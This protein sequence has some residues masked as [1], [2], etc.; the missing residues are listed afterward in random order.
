MSMFATIMQTI[1][2]S[3]PLVL[4][5]L[6]LTTLLIHTYKLMAMILHACTCDK[7]LMLLWQI[8]NSYKNK[9]IV[10]GW[11]GMYRYKI[12]WN[13]LFLMNGSVWD[14]ALILFFD[15][16]F[17]SLNT[18]LM[19]NFC[20]FF[21][22]IH[23]WCEN[24]C[25]FFH[26][27][28]FWCRISVFFSLNTL[29]KQKLSNK[30][31]APKNI[32]SKTGTFWQWMKRKRIFMALNSSCFHSPNIQKIFLHPNSHTVM[33]LQP[34]LIYYIEKKINLLNLKDPL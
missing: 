32:P 21:H 4:S 28:H 25:V 27:I 15:A 13:N 22:Y 31:F 18:L 26:W 33:V 34:H 5:R 9:K 10:L 29:L 3:L 23:L 17:F 6:L 7:K 14:S 24:F 20:I 30:F 8:I 1:A 16:K 19:Q 2:F 11:E 12:D